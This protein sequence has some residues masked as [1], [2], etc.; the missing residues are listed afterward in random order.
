ML[1]YVTNI[2]CSD[3]SQDFGTLDKMEEG[4]EFICICTKLSRLWE[5]GNLQRT[6]LKNVYSTRIHLF[7]FSF[8]NN[9]KIV[10][11][12]CYSANI[13]WCD[14]WKLEYDHLLGI[15]IK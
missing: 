12:E 3:V 8:E 7:I 1:H 10:C 14:A 11:N 6:R 13:S 2:L 15:D 9:L 4:K 5:N